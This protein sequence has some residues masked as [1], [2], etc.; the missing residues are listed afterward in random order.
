MI[1]TPE[2]NL[3]KKLNLKDIGTS[4]K[5]FKEVKN[6]DKNYSILGYGN[7]AYV[8][9]MLG[10]DNKYYSVKKIDKHNPKFNLINF[11]RETKISNKL[12]H[13][14]LVRFYGYFED[15]EK[16]EKFK[17]IKRD[18]ITKNKNKYH[19]DLRLIEK[20]M[21]DKDIYCI[22]REFIQNGSLEDFIIKYKADC[23]SK[24]SFIPLD[25]DIVIKFLEQI[26]SA[27]KYLHSKK[28]AH[29]DIK[30][31]NIL[32]DENNNIKISIPGITVLFLEEGDTEL[33]GEDELVSHCTRVGRRDFISPEIE[34]GNKYDYRCDIY[35]LGLTILLLNVRR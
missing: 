24:G 22:V 19:E 31:D 21:E 26:L 32:L 28:I 16:I 4:L 11:I 30:P 33:E 13:E 17:E 18:L 9:K 7:N 14:N 23:I 35:S 1:S 15:K 34:K 20:E 10:K 12:N 6:K 3:E 27:L 8:E 29:R 2:E 5:D 25:Q